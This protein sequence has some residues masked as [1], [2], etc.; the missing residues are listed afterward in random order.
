M[1]LELKQKNE[2]TV[3]LKPLTLWLVDDNAAY[4]QLLTEMFVQSEAMYGIYCERQFSSAEAMLEALRVEPTPDVILSDVQM[5][6]MSGVDAVTPIKR[7]SSRVRVVL[8]TAFYDSHAALRA[9]RDGAA[10][11]LL[12]R[13]TFVQIAAFVRDPRFARQMLRSETPAATI[14]SSE[15]VDPAFLCQNPHRLW[16]WW[17][18]GKT[19]L[20][21]FLRSKTPASYLPKT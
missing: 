15:A 21:V 13:Y 11:F 9:H 2:A 16:Q 20:G 10:A 18:A 5:R 7:L 17:E 14:P 4:R 19:L 8:L 12:K 6:G 3:E 1:N